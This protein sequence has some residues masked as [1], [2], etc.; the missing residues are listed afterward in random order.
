MKRLSCL[1]ILLLCCLV[2]FDTGTAYAKQKVYN[3]PFIPPF[4]ISQESIQA[5]TKITEYNGKIYH[6][7]DDPHRV[8]KNL[9]YPI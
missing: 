1:V 2:L 8:Q 3:T 4:E 5:K 6:M 7:D 9:K